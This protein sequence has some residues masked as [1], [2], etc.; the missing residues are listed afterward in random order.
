M[1]NLE[2]IHWFL[3]EDCNLER[4]AYCF[5]PL[6]GNE[7][8]PERDAQLARVLVENGVKEVI[9]GGG[10]PTLARNLEE[11]LRILKDGGVY[12]SLHTNGLLLT[13]ERLERWEGLIDDIAL[14]ID[15]VDRNIQRQLRGEG[16][17]GV[18][19]NLMEWAN[20]IN[21]K[22]IEMGWHTVFTAVNS[23]EAPAIYPMINEQRFKYWRVY[24]YNSDLARQAWSRVEELSEREKLE[25]LGTPEKGGT[26]CLLADFLRME[27]RMAQFGDSRIQFVARKDGRKEPYA[28][29]T[30]SGRVNFYAWYSGDRWRM[31]GDISR[32]GFR[33]VERKWGEIKEMNEYDE[34]ERIEADMEMPFWVRLR[35]GSG[36]PD[37]EEALLPEYEPEV[38]R[39]ANL[40][41]ERNG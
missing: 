3:R 41:Q 18:F 20:K 33:E 12:V 19:D 31:L 28:F 36:C 24:E 17:M 4:C 29:L 21:S 25:N 38:E 37:E 35:D 34:D 10:E 9:L 15:A 32:D 16:F 26:D 6:P 1:P 5:G 39:L 7:V 13:D 11:V 27:E 40:W 30:N 8:S 23:G 14:P 2:R 22:G